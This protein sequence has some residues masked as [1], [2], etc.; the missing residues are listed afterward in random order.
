MSN[1]KIEALIGEARKAIEIEQHQ[2]T[3]DLIALI[4]E[5]IDEINKTIADLKAAVDRL[6]KRPNVERVSGEGDG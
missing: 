1:M 2:A 3:V 5:D 4:Q 6:E